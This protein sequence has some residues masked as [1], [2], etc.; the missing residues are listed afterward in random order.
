MA[1]AESLVRDDPQA[2]PRVRSVRES[3]R[4]PR[5]VATSPADL[6]E[7]VR[8]A[9]AAVCDEVGEGKVAVIH[10]ASMRVQVRDL[11]PECHDPAEALDATVAAFTV[12]EVRGLEFD[13]VVVVEPGAIA[14]EHRHGRHALYVAVTR[15]VQ[16]LCVVHTTPWPP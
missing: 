3:G 8:A 4:P 14:A 11:V 12:E 1:V 10:P 15:A 16:S 5:F 2:A 6:E 7:A 9:L 13:G